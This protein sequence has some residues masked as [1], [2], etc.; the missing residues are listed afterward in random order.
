MSSL[1]LSELRALRLSDLVKMA[2]ALN[3]ENAAGLKK[4]ELI[5]EIVRA[6]AGP[7]GGATGAGVLETLSDGFGFLRSP[8]CHYLPGPDDI[9]VSPSQIRRFSLRTGDL[10]VGQV[11]APKEQER[12]FA[13]IKIERV[14]GRSPEAERERL[15]FDNLAPAVARRRV[16]LEGGGPLAGLVDRFAPVGFGHRVAVLTPNRG[17]RSTLV[18]ELAAALAQVAPEALVLALLV[19]ERPEEIGALAQAIR[20]EVMATSLDEGPSRHIQVAE[21]ALERAKRLVEQGRDVVFFV[22]SLS[23]LARAFNA[24]A[25]A[26]GRE[27]R[28]GVD[29]AAVQKAR[30]FFGAGRALDE[31]GSL[32]VICTLLT[33]TGHEVDELLLQEVAGTANVEL[34][35]DAGLV[36]QGRWPAL[37]LRASFSRDPERLLGAELA[38]ELLAARAELPSDPGEAL[39]RG[40]GARPI[41]GGPGPA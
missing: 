18:R 4:Q 20:G 19:D 34:S 38:R 33:G 36:A 6:K 27:L 37:D 41:A 10:V 7:T 30:R 13:L 24:A 23:R 3:V 32:T 15:L 14:N 21:M 5:F 16:P 40:L 17:G 26:G 12:Y 1:D 8:D 31:G 2:R 29:L 28:G 39:Q 35:V 11:R 25:P 22:D 9:Y